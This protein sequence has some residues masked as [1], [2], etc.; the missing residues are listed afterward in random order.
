ML[1][2]DYWLI[3]RCL[4]SVLLLLASALFLT[5]EPE[6]SL[7]NFNSLAVE[8]LVQVLFKVDWGSPVSLCALQV[9]RLS[10]FSHLLIGFALV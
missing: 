5:L 8:V 6:N 9:L 4:R 2:V 3:G 10:C 7:L 1:D